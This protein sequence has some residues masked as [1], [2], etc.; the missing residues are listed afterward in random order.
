M[1]IFELYTPGFG[2]LG[3]LGFITLI[4]CVLYT[5][6]TV[7]QG[8]ILTSIFFVILFILFVLF[9]SLLSKRLP[10]NLVL[11]ETEDGFTGIEDMQFLLGKIGTIVSTCR[12][13]GNADFDGVKL[14]VVS[15]GEFIEKGKIVE[16]VEIEG[17]R[18]VVRAKE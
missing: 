16:V 9:F 11:Q 12:P 8:I 1:V 13:A 4:I 18:I 6:E 7:I 15:R 2:V 10:K 17:N 14:D 3:V 5:A